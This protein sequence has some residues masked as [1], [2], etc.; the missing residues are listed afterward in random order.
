[1]D[2]ILG[3]QRIE[4]YSQDLALNGQNSVHSEV[5]N[6]CA[7]QSGNWLQKLNSVKSLNLVLSTHAIYSVFKKKKS[8]SFPSIFCFVFNCLCAHSVVF[9]SLQPH[10]LQPTSLICPWDSPGK[11]AGMGCRFLLQGIFL[12]QRSKLQLLH[13]RRFFTAEPLEKPIH[14]LVNIYSS[15]F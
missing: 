12:S 4:D 7:E 10:G 6:S 9:N 14:N 3:N 1:M 5:I 11:N 8:H 13:C 15:A 2:Y